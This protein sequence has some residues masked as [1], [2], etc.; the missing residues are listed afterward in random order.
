MHVREKKFF[1]PFRN[2]HKEKK[3][4]YAMMNTQ[5]I[6]TFE[7]ELVG[8]RRALEAKYNADL[9][10]VEASNMAQRKHRQLQRLEDEFDLVYENLTERAA[11]VAE[12]LQLDKEKAIR[13]QFYNNLIQVL[14][15]VA[16]LGAQSDT[17]FN[18]LQRDA[19]QFRPVALSSSE[20]R[21]PSSRDIHRLQMST[22]TMLSDLRRLEQIT[23]ILIRIDPDREDV[24]A[25]LHDL[26]NARQ[27]TALIHRL[28]LAALQ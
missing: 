12:Q 11:A 2:D 18:A 25:H 23:A 5:Q 4:R 20:V 15:N 21:E 27:L 26:Q 8:V 13:A 16:A 7:P 22:A 3:R 14:P 9:R 10:R 24:L 28:T 17:V 6:V 1:L 19:A